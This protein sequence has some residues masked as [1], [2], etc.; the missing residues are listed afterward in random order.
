MKAMSP[1]SSI[2][3]AARRP[4]GAGRS[5][6]LACGIAAA[7]TSCATEPA[8]S[9]V[10]AGRPESEEALA[11]RNSYPVLDRAE[12]ALAGAGLAPDSDAMLFVRRQRALL[13]A[14]ARGEAYLSWKPGRS[15]PLYSAL[16]FLEMM[17]AA[18]IDR[19]VANALAG[20]DPYSGMT[21]LIER[22]YLP[23]GEQE[24]DSFLVYVPASYRPGRPAPLALFLHGMGDGAYLNQRSPAY[25]D[26]LAACERRGVIM[27]APNGLHRLPSSAG[28]YFGDSEADVLRVLGIVEAAYSID[29]KRVY[30]TGLSMGGYGT[31]SIASRH[32]ELFAA[33]APVC[34]F[35][36]EG[37]A[38]VAGARWPA[39]DLEPLRAMPVWA[40]HGDADPVVP[41]GESRS[42]V[43]GLRA[44]GNEA[45]YTEYPGVGHEAWDHAYAGGALLDWLL[46]FALP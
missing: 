28:G 42:L 40:F 44:L 2:P 36:A 23:E 39:V 6:I 4:V 16:A 45:R 24:P 33:I 3:R 35:G 8:S 12:A 10:P 15:Q 26:F 11:P 32:P 29:P 9:G 18:T 27:A 13:D 14:L 25:N 7:I 1:R 19:L 17:D 46:S 38:I 43:E 34:G 22:A 20:R 21:R 41:V 37:S 30:L 31:L 5:F